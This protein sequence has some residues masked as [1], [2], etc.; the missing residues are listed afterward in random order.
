MNKIGSYRFG[1]IVINGRKYTSDVIISA[2]GVKADWR[3]KIGHE[4]S[5]EDISDI[6]ASNPEVLVVGTGASGQM[7]VSPEVK[8][9]ISNK[10]IKLIEETTE[11]ACDTY[12]QLSRQQRVVAALHVTC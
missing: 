12:N 2:D 5:L 3:R 8:Q 7:K 4:L 6:I 11:E 9:T 10:G 1:Q